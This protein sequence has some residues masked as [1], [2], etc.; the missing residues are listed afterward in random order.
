MSVKLLKQNYV[1]KLECLDGKEKLRVYDEKLKGL[2]LEVRPTG[3]KTY[4]L[5]YKT[6]R[7][8]YKQIKLGR[9]SF[10]S[11]EQARDIAAKV[12]A[13][14]A[15]GKDPQDE[16]KTLKVVPTF[17]DFAWNS[18]LPYVQGY[19]RSWKSDLSFL[20]THLVPK[21]GKL[22]LD[23]ITRDDIMAMHQERLKN[24]AAPASANRLVILLRYMFNLAIQWETPGVT[25]NP[26]KGVPLAEENN[27]RERYLTEEEV[28]RLCKAVK[29][30][31]NPLLEPII[32]MLILTG[33]R[34]SEVLN[35]K[36]E[37]LD[38]ERK[39]W[40]IPYTKSG[41]PRTVPLSESALEVLR[42]VPKVEGSEYIFPSPV[43]GKPF[44]SIYNSWNTARIKSGLE[45]VKIHT[46]RH[47][48]ASFLVNAGRNL[49]EVGKLLG[50]TQMRTTM[51]YSHLSDETLA[52]AVNT[53]PLKKVA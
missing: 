7:G 29:E 1:N 15:M 28:Q 27:Q 41:K 34:K 33:A 25:V 31:E 43:T 30:S 21:F 24:G 18:Y 45:D 5:K 22:H 17:E 4:F 37:D 47:S 26:T 2:M 10:L 32:S 11:V 48:F 20:R 51:R 12:L 14:V 8:G 9:N 16:K 49:Y 6:P 23:Q 36:W 19:K 52:E 3:I 42:S 35:A 44:N 38:L 40:R 46:L 53:V 39:R 50:H 13:D